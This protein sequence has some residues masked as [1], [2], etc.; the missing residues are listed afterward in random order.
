MEVYLKVDR[1]GSILFPVDRTAFHIALC[2]LQL[3]QIRLCLQRAYSDCV[4]FCTL[5]ALRLLSGHSAA[6][7]H[8]G[9]GGYDRAADA[10]DTIS[11][12]L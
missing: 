9:G 12:Y 2:A 1:G 7:L 4:F 5:Y 8:R 11:F 10:A 6:S 3:S